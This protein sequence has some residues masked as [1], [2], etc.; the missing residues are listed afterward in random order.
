MVKKKLIIILLFALIIVIGMICT[1][2][3]IKNKKS[4]NVEYQEFNYEGKE[5]QDLVTEAIIEHQTNNTSVVEYISEKVGTDNIK[6]IEN[7]KYQVIYKDRKY[8][9][10]EKSGGNYEILNK[11]IIQ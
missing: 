11:G 9:L 1:F 2:N 4:E 5:F 3:Y 6:E 10:N 8:E 7:G